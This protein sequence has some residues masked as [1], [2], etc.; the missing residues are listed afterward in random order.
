MLPE[1]NAIRANTSATSS[2]P[3]KVIVAL[4]FFSAIGAF[5]IFDLKSYLSLDTLKAN[6]DNLLVF[7]QDHYV[8]AVALFIL[9]YLQTAFSL[10]GATIMTLAGGFLFGSLWARFTSISEPR[11]M[12]HWP[13]SPRA[14]CFI[15]GWSESLVIGS[16][17]FRMALQRT[18]SVIC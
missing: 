7:T 11:P 10:P 3:G 6:R 9:V 16:A 15:S 14:I 17:R 18:A 4:L 2:I 12:R 1:E 13:F 5:F 8:P